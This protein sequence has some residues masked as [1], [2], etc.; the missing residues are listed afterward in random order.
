MHSA[1]VGMGAAP[2]SVGLEEF[3]ALTPEVRAARRQRAVDW[4]RQALRREATRDRVQSLNTAAGLAPDLAETWLDLAEIWSWAGGHLQADAS[5]PTAEIAKS[6][7]E[8]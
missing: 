7:G 8:Q 2:D 3:M 6:V 4:R 1:P 5:L